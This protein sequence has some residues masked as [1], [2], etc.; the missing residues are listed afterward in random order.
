MPAHGSPAAPSPAPA[1]RAARGPACARR[2]TGSRR[3][4]HGRRPPWPGRSG[5]ASAGTRS[6]PARC[7]RPAASRRARSVPPARRTRRTAAPWPTADWRRTPRR[8]ARCRRRAPCRRPGAPCRSRRAPRRTPAPRSGRSPPPRPCPR[9]PSEQREFGP[10][11]R[12]VVAGHAELRERSAF[13]EFTLAAAL[14][15][16]L[17]QRGV[18]DPAAS[19]A[20]GLGVRAFATAFTQWIAP[21]NDQPFPTLARHGLT[22]LHQA[23]TTL[24]WHGRGEPP[25]RPVRASFGGRPADPPHPD[26]PERWWAGARDGGV[27]A[28]VPLFLVPGEAPS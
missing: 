19:L 3:P 9:R 26:G 27:G 6:G 20:A 17:R 18:P 11:F 24:T 23:A 2:T 7:A 13:K 16:A 25:R 21:A 8:D 14:T 15:G 1:G 28:R 4:R 12:S 22:E 10:R 5:S